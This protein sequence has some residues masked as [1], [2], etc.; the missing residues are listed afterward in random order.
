MF[1]IL[2]IFISGDFIKIFEPEYSLDSV[3]VYYF[4]MQSLNCP[5][6]KNPK[7]TWDRV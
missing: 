5:V 2:E 7:H 3:F 6:G 1:S 4:K